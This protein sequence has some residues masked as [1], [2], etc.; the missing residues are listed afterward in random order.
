MTDAPTRAHIAVVGGGIAGL[1]AAYHAAESG[2]R[3]TLLEG[4]PDVGGKLRVSEIGGLA[5]DEGAEA[6]LARRPEGLELVRE[7]GIGDR[8]AYPGTTSAAIWSRGALHDMPGGHVMGVPADLGA[9]ARSRVLSA[10]GLAR[11]PLD[12]LRGPTPRGEDVSVA[13]LVGA[14]LGAE[15][16]DRLVEP[17]LGGVYAGR[18]DDLS[19]EA[20]MPGL[21]D[22]ART[23]RSLIAAARA[24]REAA[25]AGSGPVF[26]T[27]SGGL[28]ELPRAMEARLGDLDVTVRT[29]MTVRELRRGTDG[30]RLTLGPTREPELLEADAV[31]LAVPARAARRLLREDVPAASAELGGIEYASMAIVTLAYS[32]SAFP[33]P[34]TRS[35]YLV[36]AVESEGVKA[37]TFTTTK[38]PHLIDS[39][40]GMVVVR[41]S[42]GRYGEEAT[43]QRPDDELKALAM[44]ELARTTGVIELPVDSRVTRWGGALPQYSVGH[45]G[46]VAR[47]RAALA[48]VPGLAVCGAAYDGVGVPAC[49]AS[50]RA[51]VAR[52]TAGLQGR[53]ESEPTGRRR[54]VPEQK[55]N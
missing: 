38:W 44:T 5:V 13:G 43:L 37:V 23:H 36:P 6:I 4:S 52:V 48:R 35:G 7:L 45:L 20:T 47:I 1:T 39:A 31:V 3:V 40:P 42:I 29:R 17:L 8:L 10:A 12:L 30:W 41:C 34:L 15:V 33:E 32:A 55:G 51:A 24:V 28:G 11:V 46:R 22:A 21:A 25:P 26:A 16:V 18:T 49:I 27:L 14:R 50:A 53:G 54:P 9:L 19:F 2:A